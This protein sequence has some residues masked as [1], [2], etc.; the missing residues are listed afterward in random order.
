LPRKTRRKRRPVYSLPQITGHALAR[1]LIVED[2]GIIAEHIASRLKKIGYA[3]AGI[4]ESSEQAFSGV[5]TLKPDLILMDIRIKGAMDGIEAAIKLRE[6]FDIPIIYLTAHSDRQT[7]E[8]AKMTGAYGFLTKPIHQN[9]LAAGIEAAIQQHR[10]ERATNQSPTVL[11][12]LAEPA[13]TLE[14]ELTPPAPLKPA[15]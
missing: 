10:A 12:K 11:P 8:R 5:A 2:E 6:L 1:I 4:A 3:V 9:A 7:I 15:L 13:V 14:G